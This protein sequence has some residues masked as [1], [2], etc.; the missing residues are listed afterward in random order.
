MFFIIIISI[1]RSYLLMTP[2]LRWE[3]DRGFFTDSL[4]RL[5]TLKYKHIFSHTNTYKSISELISPP[6]PPAQKL[7]LCASWLNHYKI[8][9]LIYNIYFVLCI[10]MSSKQVPVTC[11]LGKQNAIPRDLSCRLSGLLRHRTVG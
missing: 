10:M 11:L 7:N 8:R 5:F 3:G 1:L 2:I 9:T 4:D 6:L